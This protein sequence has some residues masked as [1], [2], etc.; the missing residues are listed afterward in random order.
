MIGCLDFGL[1]FWLF[2]ILGDLGDFG[3]LG[4]W[5]FGILLFWI[6]FP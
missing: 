3:T 4:L 2:D 6:L 1:F 5:D